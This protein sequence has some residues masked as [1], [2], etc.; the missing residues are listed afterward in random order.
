MAK[1]LWSKKLDKDYIVK[2]QQ[3]P[4]GKYILYET[5][6]RCVNDRRIDILDTR[7]RELDRSIHMASDAICSTDSEYVYTKDYD[8]F[9]VY[10]FKT[11]ARI[12]NTLRVPN[13][14]ILSLSPDGRTIA[15]SDRYTVDYNKIYFYEWALG[16]ELTCKGTFE[17]FDCK[18]S[19]D[20]ST[21]VLILENY[22]RVSM[23]DAK[24][25]EELWYRATDTMGSFSSDGSKFFFNG[26]IHIEELSEHDKIK[27]R[28]HVDENGELLGIAMLETR[29]GNVIWFQWTCDLIQCCAQS[30]DDQTAVTGSM[31]YDECIIMWDA[32]TG[33]ELWRAPTKCQVESCSYA[34]DGQSVLIHTENKTARIYDV[35]TGEKLW[36]SLEDFRASIKSIS[37]NPQGGSFMFSRHKEIRVMKVPLCSWRPQNHKYQDDE[38]KDR[39]E[40][41]FQLQASES[42]I[43]ALPNEIL[44]QICGQ[45]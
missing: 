29:T 10:S 35:L 39:I 14:Q 15:V 38:V 44:F 43:S 6:T 2:C 42:P 13:W 41:I 22:S 24:T 27:F 23:R 19:P 4:N 37:Y 30:H 20:G 11:C 32:Q 5:S 3:S 21:F 1:T 25:Y 36:D 45:L 16:E 18:F 7:T 12:R 26:S 33:D 34:P 28:D 8:D 31:M 17:A 40:T 9:L